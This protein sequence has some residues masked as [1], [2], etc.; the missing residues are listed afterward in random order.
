MFCPECGAPNDEDSVYCG[1]C[2]ALMEPGEV[3]DTE[4]V[5][6]APAADSVQERIADIPRQAPGGSLEGALSTDELSLAPSAPEPRLAADRA[7]LPQTS[8]MAI[9]SLAM[10]I[11]GWTLFPFL[12]SIL[13]IIFGYAARR[14]IRRQPG[15]LTGDGMAVA[16]LV[17]GWIMVGL[18][19]AGIILGAIG[20]CLLVSVS[21]STVGY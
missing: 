17:L 18:G 20:L 13:A 6:G 4:E 3:P 8:G 9:A 19:V 21:S 16:G 12:G 5:G 7:V 15:R 1:N 11:A 10:G 2:G 14:E